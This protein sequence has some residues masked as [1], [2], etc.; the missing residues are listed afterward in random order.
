MNVLT[1]AGIDLVKKFEGC[2]LTAYT[3]PAGKLTIGYGHTGDGVIPGLTIT[4]AQAEAILLND[5]QKA[6]SYVAWHATVPLT[7]DQFSALS[8]FVFNLGAGAFLGSTLLKKLN[9]GDTD[10]AA[11]EILRWD[12]CN[13]EILPG[14][15]RR[16][17]AERELFVGNRADQS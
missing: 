5:L 16:R 10:G 1:Q 14:L 15:S 13:G 3:C 17:F 6:G 9:A 8:S 12:H 11:N 2:K 7:D 4:Q